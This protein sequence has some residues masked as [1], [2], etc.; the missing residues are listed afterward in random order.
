M[1]EKTLQR[2]LFTVLFGFFFFLFAEL[3]A[4]FFT[5]ILWS[6]LLYLLF[7]PLY[8]FII[9][10]W[11]PDARTFRQRRKVLA[12]LFSIFSVLFIIAPLV[13]ITVQ[14][15]QQLFSLGGQLRTY[16]GQNPDLLTLKLDQQII[17]TLRTISFDTIKIDQIDIKAELLKLLQSG[18]SQLIGMLTTAVKNLSIFA[19]SLVFMVFTLYFF[20]VDG[21]H[22]LEVFVRAIPIHDEYLHRFIARFR[23]SAS[24]LFRGFVLVAL[25][26]A[27]AAFVLMSIFGIKQALLLGV[28][29]FFCSFVP[30][31][32]AGAV[33]GPVGV[34]IILTTSPLQGLVFI[35][36]SAF[37]VSTMD[38]FIRPLVLKNRINIHPLLIFF[39][40]MGGLVLFGF[41]GLVLGPMI[42]ILFFTIMDI[43]IELSRLEKKR[44]AGKDGCP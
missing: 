10:G 16:M 44:S 13:F 40:L 4:P 9:K 3:F 27:S 35:A 12:G 20:Y 41:N 29:A 31:L 1:E 30:M 43:F 28:L 22:L 11:N 36:L 19:L 32:G 34:S 8:R 39:S 26:Q 5:I 6:V 23:E 2:I 18:T 15:V 14:M 25:Y 42:V 17:N 37:F 24:G 7:S 21:T 38:N 33:W